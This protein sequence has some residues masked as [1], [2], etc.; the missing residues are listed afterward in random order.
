MGI[1]SNVQ[2]G[3]ERTISLRKLNAENLQREME[4]AKVESSTTF[5]KLIQMT[6]LKVF[7]G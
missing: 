6:C 7:E 4:E 3:E 2:R 1:L 5:V